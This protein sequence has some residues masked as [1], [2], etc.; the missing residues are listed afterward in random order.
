MS[1][2]LEPRIQVL[3][4]PDWASG[5]LVE[6]VRRGLGGRPRRLPPTWLYDDEGSRLFDEITRLPEYYP[7]EAERAILLG[8]ADA[9]AAACDA[10]T[11]VE[12]GSGTSDK[13][14]T[15][16]D[17]FR[18]PGRPGGPLDRFVPVDVS[19]ATLREAATALSSRYPGM[20]VEAVVGD[21]TLHLGHLPRGGRR[22][23]A[24]LGSTIGNFYVE[25]RAAFLGALADCLDPGEWLLLGTD[26]VKDL[27]RLVA[28]YDDSQGVTERFIRNSLVV[29]NRQ[30]GADFDPGAFSYVPFWD[31]RMERVDMRLRAEEPQ[32]VTVPGAQLRVD[33]AT[34]EEIHVEIS[35]KFRPEGIRA[36]LDEAGFE[37]TAT[38]SD[39]AG[40]FALTLARRR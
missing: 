4:D 8:H 28:A 9:I 38:W 7:T 24:F 12:L 30:L 22:M 14:R 40:D 20:A 2:V 17:A 39:P 33:L 16:L 25:E 21:F 37:V 5:S 13:T 3:L 23:V 6:D 36:E 34:G 27:D 31:P 10:T 19:D 29:L 15:L 11:I 1:E 26:L 32:V 18:R 35:T